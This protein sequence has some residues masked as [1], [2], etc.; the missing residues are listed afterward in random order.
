MVGPDSWYTSEK[1]DIF[2]AF[3]DLR[4]FLDGVYCFLLPAGGNDYWVTSDNPLGSP[5]HTQETLWICSPGSLAQILG[6]F[7]SWVGENPHSGGYIIAQ[8]G[9]VVN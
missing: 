1:L 7:L 5:A 9:V 4:V 3:I 2:S 8:F 6:P